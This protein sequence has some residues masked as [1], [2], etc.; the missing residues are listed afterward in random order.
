MRRTVFEQRRYSTAD[1]QEHILSAVFF[2][3]LTVL[4]IAVL[5]LRVI[6]KRVNYL[7]LLSVQCLF[8]GLQRGA[9]SGKLIL[10]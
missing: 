2:I 9:L 7:L 4:W 3:T 1:G 6:N 8:Y 10:R 5:G